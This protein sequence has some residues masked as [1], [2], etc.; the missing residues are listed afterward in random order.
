[1]YEISI[2]SDVGKA[3]AGLSRTKSDL[4]NGLIQA[5]RHEAAGLQEHIVRDYLSGQAL[6]RRSGALSRSIA[7]GHETFLFEGSSFRGMSIQVGTNKEYAAYHE[8]GFHGVE[9]VKA[10]TRKVASR[11]VVINVAKRSSKSGELYIGRE[12]SAQGIAFVRAHDRRVNY[13][14]HP[15]IR[16]ATD[17]RRLSIQKHLAEAALKAFKGNES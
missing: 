8:F 1:M 14:G 11:D 13:G 7:F 5:T 15:F 17:D 6:N 9:N 3:I 16:P 12:K 10:H 2:R 4:S